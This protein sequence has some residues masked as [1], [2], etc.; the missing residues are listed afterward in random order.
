VEQARLTLET[1]QRGYDEQVRMLRGQL[2]HYC[3]GVPGIARIRDAVVRAESFA[4]IER[5][6]APLFAENDLQSSP[7]DYIAP[8]AE[9]VCYIPQ[10]EAV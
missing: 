1:T 6:L 8:E 2:S 10:A 7:A 5:A 9:E 3:K 4:D